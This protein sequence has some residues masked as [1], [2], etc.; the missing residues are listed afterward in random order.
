MVRNLIQKSSDEETGGYRFTHHVV[1]LH[2]YENLS[3][4]FREETHQK[5]AVLLEKDQGRS[6]LSQKVEDLAYHFVNGKKD[7]S[8]LKKAVDYLIQAGQ[9]MQKQY[10]ES[11]AEQY[12]LQALGFL[13]DVPSSKGKHSK[14]FRLLECLG[15][16]QTRIGKSD[17][18]ID[19]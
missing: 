3:P 17:S 7:R 6:D 18:A 8:S 16:V 9:K 13:K 11:K 14:S 5:V 2:I 15:D 4:E 19:S 10:S 1:L 12:F